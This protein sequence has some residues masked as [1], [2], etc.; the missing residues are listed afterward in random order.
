M[1]RWQPL[2]KLLLHHALIAVSL[3]WSFSLGWQGGLPLRVCCLFLQWPRFAKDGMVL[4][5]A[6][7]QPW[8][9]IIYPWTFP[10]SRC[11]PWVWYETGR[12]CQ[13]FRPHNSP[14]KSCCPTLRTK[15]RV[16]MFSGPFTGLSSLVLCWR[17]GLFVCLRHV[18]GASVYTACL[19]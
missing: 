9:F 1:Q 13:I 17:Q 19:H 11:G 2:L 18:S 4:G 12:A 7:Q 8:A 10:F 3:C 15:R 16:L 5:E 6:S 14:S